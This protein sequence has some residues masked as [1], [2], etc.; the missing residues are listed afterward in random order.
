MV[1]ELASLPADK[2]KQL[3]V[4]GVL[5]LAVGRLAWAPHRASAVHGI[6]YRAFL[7]RALS[8]RCP[9]RGF[10]RPEL[11]R[12]GHIQDVRACRKAL[13]VLGAPSLAGNRPAYRKYTENAIA[14]FARSPHDWLP[15]VLQKYTRRNCTVSRRLATVFALCIRCLA[16]SSRQPTELPR[17]ILDD[18]SRYSTVSHGFLRYLTDLWYISHRTSVRMCTVL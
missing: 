2:P 7:M 17:Y 16:D 4:V 13:A 15:G 8:C 6:D 5:G 10:H 3:G 11:S 9:C 14:A 18:S 12:Y 1:S